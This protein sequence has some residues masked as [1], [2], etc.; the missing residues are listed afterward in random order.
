MIRAASESTFGE[1]ISGYRVVEIVLPGDT[2]YLARAQHLATD[3]SVLLRI[4]RKREH[5]RLHHKLR[6]E[7][8]LVSDVVGP[9][10]VRLLDE[11]YFSGGYA[12]VL[13]DIG[14]L[15]LRHYMAQAD[16]SDVAVL[17]LMRACVEGL[18]A[19]HD[20][21]YSYRNFSPESIIVD[22]ATARI[23]LVD[24]S[25]CVPLDV[26]DEFPR[27]LLPEFLPYMA[28][29]HSR[30]LSG[31]EDQ[32]ADFYSLGVVLYEC[33]SHRLPFSV[34]DPLDW[35]HAHLTQEPVPLS[36]YRPD[37]HP[38]VAKLAGQLLAKDPE[39][40]Y[41]SAAAL[42]SDFDTCL[43]FIADGTPGDN[44][45]PANIEKYSSLRWS[46]EVYGREPEIASL[47]QA[48]HES[49]HGDTVVA[50][51]SGPTGIG[52]SAMLGEFIRQI[53]VDTAHAP[54]M[55]MVGGY[56]AADGV[57][58]QGLRTALSHAAVRVLG[59]SAEGIERWRN[60]MQ[61]A[62]DIDIAVLSDFL[63]VLSNLLAANAKAAE[64][65]PAQAQLRL[66]RTLAGF[67]RLMAKFYPHQLI[68][69]DDMQWCDQGTRDWLLALR[70]K[71]I[72]G[73]LVLLSL[74][75]SDDDLRGDARQW[76]ASLAEAFPGR[77]LEI[78]LAPIGKSHV[79]SLLCS[80]LHCDA[81]QAEPLAETL[82][83]KTD[84]NPFFL[85]QILAHAVA[86][87]IFQYSDERGVWECVDGGLEQLDLGDNVV[88]LVLS[89]INTLPDQELHLL[90][91]AAGI[92][93]RFDI[94]ALSVVAEKMLADTNAPLKHAI[95]QNIVCRYFDYQSQVFR[96]RFQHDRIYQSFRSLIRP[97]LAD[98]VNFTYGDYLLQGPDE[99]REQALG[100]LNSVPHLLKDD[101]R[102]IQLINMNLDAMSHV[103]LQGAVSVAHQFAVSALSLLRQMPQSAYESSLMVRV[104]RG[105]GYTAVLQGMFAYAEECLS[106][107]TPLAGNVEEKAELAIVHILLQMHSGDWHG[108]AATG[109]AVLAEFDVDL[110]Q[111]ADVE[112]VPEW[113]RE[114]ADTEPEQLLQ[115]APMHNP[116]LLA[117]SR[118][119][120]VVF[121]PI[122]VSKPEL[123]PAVLGYILKISRIHGNAP[124]SAHAY[125]NLGFITGT[126]LGDYAK[127]SQFAQVALELA[128]RTETNEFSAKVLVSCAAVVTHWTQ[129]LQK[130]IELA[131]AGGV[132]GDQAGDAIYGG[133]GR[134]LEG[135]YRFSAGQPLQRV[136]A[137]VAAYL[138]QLVESKNPSVSIFQVLDGL[139][140][141]LDTSGVAD[142]ESDRL[143][144]DEAEFVGQLENTGFTHGLHYFYMQKMFLALLFGDVDAALKFGEQSA[145]HM[146]GVLGQLSN[147]EQYFFYGLAI[148]EKLREQADDAQLLEKLDVCREK[149]A[150]WAEL[151]P[152]N[153]QAQSQLL[154]AEFSDLRQ[155]YW[156][157]LQ[158]YDAA[159]S[160]ARELNNHFL[161]AL[162]CERAAYFWQRQG[163]REF[164][165][166]YAFEAL[167]AYTVWGAWRK[168]RAM[169]VEFN[170]GEQVRQDASPEPAV[171]TESADMFDLVSVLNAARVITQ[172]L[173]T[174]QLMHDI[175]EIVAKN[176]GARFGIILAAQDEGDLVFGAGYGVE[177]EQNLPDSVINYV[178][179]TGNS[180]RIN[181]GIDSTI[182]A[183]DP[184][185][186]V[187]K[188]ASLLCLPVRHHDRMLGIV[189]L[190]H[191]SIAGAFPDDRIRIVN[192]LLDQAGVAIE[193]ARLYDHLTREIHRRTEAQNQLEQQQ[194]GLER[195]ISKRTSELQRTQKELLAKSRLA[196]LGTLTATVSHEIRNPLAAA[197]A[198]LHILNT[199]LQNL[200]P[201]IAA[202]LERITRSLRRCDQ[203]VDELLDFAKIRSVDKQPVK[204][205]VWLRETV[206][207]QGAGFA[208]N[209]DLNLPDEL[210]ALDADRL[211]RAVINVVTNAAQAIAETPSG[212]DNCLTVRTRH[213]EERLELVFIDTGSG[214]SEEVQA[215][216]F[217]PMFSTKS[218]GVGLGM[219]TVK[220]IMELH[221]GGVEVFPRLGHGT[222]VILWLPL[223]SSSSA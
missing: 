120:N 52:K 178:Y 129:P 81:S 173:D 176:S 91:C 190:E 63:P 174:R 180:V 185:L 192:L 95:N 163:K 6:R 13:E 18:Q 214:M 64:L 117:V 67:V 105:C 162:A 47:L 65:E 147:F 25:Q 31:G 74:R 76:L 125:A 160:G 73:L 200:E 30:R 212:G 149:L 172:Q 137:C 210:V 114:I 204:L 161:V 164:S 11:A 40:R 177:N 122:Y 5:Q 109:L 170:S 78:P 84:G 191:K 33:L 79:Q 184:Y 107:A 60:A 223:N 23:N 142:L 145:L 32:R 20:Q 179:R 144:G 38:V 183:S 219:P 126:V 37:V 187:Q 2:C 146:V 108:A 70:A 51:C 124:A 103:L 151:N 138:P 62:D 132:K 110:C 100:Y 45:V 46:P 181:S 12:L 83:R 154:E 61:G 135:I 72:P 3:T 127:G 14:G 218:F 201:P 134:L 68:Y 205:D 59:E 75:L 186:M 55:V 121:S 43:Q 106:I 123:V 143:V 206:N 77:Y 96:Y 1:A 136:R 98:H 90:M 44:F 16:V 211:R 27:D 9:G 196:T 166:Q 156:R 188:P 36:E 189:Y 130:S 15:P 171:L 197:L 139:L 215:R 150:A 29:E 86:K 89:R 141:A 69:L 92:G 199:K 133:F 116:E 7:H 71:E 4:T 85:R 195:L 26:V 165:R 66:H 8:Q 50:V 58:Y 48:Y 53:Q 28:P 148:S 208:V 221:G 57:P 19:L 10:I 42:I 209:Y 152:Q 220:Q 17:K 182:F 115:L 22:P 198:S 101:A 203:I 94:S 49:M 41:Q 39:Q 217:E 111:A 35:V 128:D 102:K 168:V 159:I 158:Q 157:A 99:Y 112:E 54:A 193:A 104:L 222:T 175:I 118:V 119:L 88:D 169:E 207:E 131:M 93:Y 194:A 80:S 56:Y 87:N 24:F 216:I 97:D 153:F 155:D 21:G 213:T 113:A 140:D 82:M 167:D 202:A 34:A